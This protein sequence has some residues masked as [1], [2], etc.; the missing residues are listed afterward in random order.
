MILF[1]LLG[2]PMVKRR[3]KPPLDDQLKKRSDNNNQTS[4]TRP[5]LAKR[6]ANTLNWE[7]TNEL[8]T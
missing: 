4:N 2:A 1:Q 5:Y 8:T 6:K 3:N 7:D